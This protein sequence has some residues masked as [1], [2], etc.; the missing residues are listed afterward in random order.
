VSLELIPKTDEAE[1]PAELKREH[2][3]LVRRVSLSATF[4]KSPRLRAF[5]LHVC[6]CAVEDKPEE[7]TEQ[8]I[9]IWVYDRAQ[10]TTQTKTILSVRRR[11]CCA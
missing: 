9:G 8:Q 11:A 7:A 10:A 4:E 5:F 2:K 1:A 3:E 6:R